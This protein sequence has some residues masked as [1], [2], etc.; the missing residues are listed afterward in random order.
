MIT[1]NGAQIL[2]VEDQ[3]PLLVGNAEANIEHALLDIVEIHEPRQQQRP[4]LGNGGADRVALLPEQIPEHNRKLVGLVVEP[5]TLG[6]AD[7]RFLGFANFGN[8][9]KISLDVGGEDRD[10]R[11]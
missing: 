2:E 3:Q 10:A 8:A 11:A 4:H 5:E 7:K 9:G 1:E 6:A